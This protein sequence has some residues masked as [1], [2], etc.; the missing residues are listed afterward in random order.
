[1]EFVWLI[2]NSWLLLMGHFR[3]CTP[4]FYELMFCL[5][6]GKTTE[7]QPGPKVWIYSKVNHLHYRIKNFTSFISHHFFSELQNSTFS[8]LLFLTISPVNYE[9]QNFHLDML[10]ST[11]SSVNYKNQNFHIYYFPPFLHW[12]I[13][14]LMF[15]SII[16]HCFFQWLI[17]LQLCPEQ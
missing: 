10:F 9:I 12:I 16:S 15:T 2:P 11:I 6:L 4:L 5:S 1:M 13:K 17:L 8:H 14:F 7:K 3:W